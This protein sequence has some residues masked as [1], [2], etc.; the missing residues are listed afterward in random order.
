MILTLDIGNTQLSGGVFKDDKIVLTF[1]CATTHGTSSDELGIFLRSVLRENEIDSRF[2]SDIADCSV[3]PSLNYAVTSACLKYFEIEPLMIRS[4]IKTGLRLRY[5]N[6]R[7][8]GA[9]RIAAAIGA[10]ALKLNNHIIVVDMGTATTV[11]VITKDSEYWGGAIL[12]GINMMM[13]AL[14]SGTAQLPSVEIVEP[15]KACGTSTVTAI[16]SG[17]YYGTLGSIRELISRFTNEVF[18]GEKPVIIATG[19]FSNLFRESGLFDRIES[20]LVLDG[21]R[22]ALELNK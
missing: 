16:Q 18:K 20:Q 19:G 2:I 22:I 6:P 7:E 1:R 13:H 15:E 17:L 11:D 12:P 9:D 5:S 3:V 14:S 10:S 21:L 4:G 8:I